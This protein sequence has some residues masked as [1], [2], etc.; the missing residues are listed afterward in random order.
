MLAV[1]GV[2]A[3]TV[4][5]TSRN[6]TPGVADA[7][8]I[9]ATVQFPENWRVVLVRDQPTWDYLRRKGDT[10][11]TRTIFTNVKGRITVVNWEIFARPNV[12]RPALRVLLHELGHILCDC[13]DENKAEKFGVFREKQ[14]KHAEMERAE[15]SSAPPTLPAESAL[16]TANSRF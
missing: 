13:E 15:S 7:T 5:T 10:F 14:L 16:T 12:A 3:A 11:A 8:K 6:C 1:S 2:H 4:Q 9:I